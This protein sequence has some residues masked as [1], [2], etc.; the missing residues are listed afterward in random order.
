MKI[1]NRLFYC[2]NGRG[3]HHNITLSDAISHSCD[4]YFYEA[5]KLITPDV[6]AAEG[7]RFHLDQRTGI[8]LPN[9]TTRML[10]PT[11]DWKEK[12]TGERW[13]PGDTAN[14]SIG[15]G[16]V[17]VSPLDMACFV[18]SVARNE[19]YTKPTL[20]HRPNSPT[21]HSEAI[22]L[23][24]DQRTALLAGMEGTTIFGTSKTINT[25]PLYHV[26]ERIAA[27]TGT[28]QKRVF[29]DGQLGNINFAWYICFAPLERPE[30]AVVV[31][32][33]GE[34]FVSAGESFGGGGNAAPIA[35]LVMK[36]YFEKR[37]H[38]SAFVAPV[39]TP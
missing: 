17:L 6:L 11:T 4:I 20:I 13:F 12:R 32:L 24:P 2:D 39:K 30:I 5:G 23:T 31:M 21:Q 19:V 33:E 14:M 34:N 28:A 8:E 3:H 9:E 29:K 1:G 7:R 35:N 22:G 25:L 15:Q 10:M 38:P 37:D 36:K 18:A 16:D 26:P 27:K